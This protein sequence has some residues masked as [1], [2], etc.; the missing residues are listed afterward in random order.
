MTTT[1]R[2]VGIH[3][4]TFEASPKLLSLTFQS[5]EEGD[6]YVAR[7]EQL[8]DAGIVPADVV[9]QREVI[10]TTLDA[11]REYLRRVSVPD[12]DSQV[13][14]TLLGRLPSKALA[15][16]DY[17]GAERRGNRDEARAAS[18]AVDYSPQCLGVRSLF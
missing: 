11:I 2:N 10:S 7:V 17:D 8:L 12:S 1:L 13:L 6:A 5:E 3:H 16:V 15:T 18:F 9:E 4:P 14:N